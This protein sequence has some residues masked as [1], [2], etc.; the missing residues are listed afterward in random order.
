VAVAIVSEEAFL[1]S[2]VVD[3]SDTL[4]RTPKWNGRGAGA[5]KTFGLAVALISPADPSPP[6]PSEDQPVETNS[7]ELIVHRSA[8]VDASQD[9]TDCEEALDSKKRTEQACGVV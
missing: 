4:P 9:W 6:W 7:T 8:L 1:A 5:W 3:A 2:A